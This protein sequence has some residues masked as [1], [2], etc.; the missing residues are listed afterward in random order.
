M[1]VQNPVLREQFVK[2]PA[3]TV[4]KGNHAQ[5][6]GHENGAI[7]LVD[8]KG[9]YDSWERI[10]YDFLASYLWVVWGYSLI[11]RIVLS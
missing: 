11:F 8:W 9:W 10:S 2:L 5:S 7:N 1:E 3:I 6:K 4:A